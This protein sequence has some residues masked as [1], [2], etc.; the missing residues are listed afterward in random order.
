MAPQVIRSIVGGGRGV[1]LR[2]VVGGGKGERACA[3]EAGEDADLSVLKAS[4]TRASTVASISG[5]ESSAIWAMAAG[6]GA[7]VGAGGGRRGGRRRTENP[8]IATNA[9][10]QSQSQRPPDYFHF[11]FPVRTQ[12]VL[13]LNYESCSASSA[14]H[15]PHITSLN[16]QKAIA[17]RMKG[18]FICCP[19][20]D[21]PKGHTAL[22]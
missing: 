6:H 21:G 12:T 4:A 1:G 16:A 7:I 8:R 11:A 18:S 2:S 20:P 19:S 13:H 17:V 10:N 14:L 5:V 22:H 15:G 3:G 9:Q